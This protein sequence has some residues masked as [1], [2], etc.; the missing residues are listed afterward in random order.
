[1][2][3]WYSGARRR[4]SLF[5]NFLLVKLDIAAEALSAA[6]WWPSYQPSSVIINTLLSVLQLVIVCF[7]SLNL[8]FS[9]S[10]I[11]LHS[12]ELLVAVYGG[13]L[14]DRNFCLEFVVLYIMIGDALKR[15]ETIERKKEEE[16]DVRTRELDHTSPS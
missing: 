10:R 2:H 4:S 16:V 5:D 11:F 14:F 12:K 3:H 13:R 6:N 8:H 9:G 7:P 15:K 1:M